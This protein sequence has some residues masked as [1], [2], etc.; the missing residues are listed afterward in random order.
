MIKHF[1][2]SLWFRAG[3]ELYDSSCEPSSC[4]VDSVRK[5]S[6]QALESQCR[7]PL[8]RAWVSLTT[9]NALAQSMKVYPSPNLI[10]GAQWGTCHVYEYRICHILTFSRSRFN[11]P[12]EII[13]TL[14]Y[15]VQK[16]MLQ[17]FAHVFVSY[18]MLATYIFATQQCIGNAPDHL[19]QNRFRKRESI[20][21]LCIFLIHQFLCIC[22][23]SS[24]C[25]NGTN[26]GWL[27]RMMQEKVVYWVHGQS[28]ILMWNNLV[29]TG[30][31]NPN[32]WAAKSAF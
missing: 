16:E 12:S 13:L 1:R 11:R 7:L 6:W 15:G 10:V 32:F 4:F 3:L 26:V 9:W 25:E 17:N 18:R 22:M 20:P 29:R 30:D 28:L 27:L 21:S 19:W 5:L 24:P 31:V 14:Q 23:S 2:H 8:V